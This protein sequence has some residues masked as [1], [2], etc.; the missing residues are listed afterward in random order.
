MRQVAA[1]IKAGD[2]ETVIESDD[3]IQVGNVV[4]GLYSAA[5]RRFGFC[6]CF[7]DKD[8]EAIRDARGTVEW[9]YYLSTEQIQDIAS[10]AITRL[11]MW[12][13]S[14]RDCGR[15]WSEP[16]GNCPRCDSRH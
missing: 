5:E 7:R 3:L 12:H 14:E 8:D 11:A 6:M 16:D 13:C 2:E 4:G 9:C 15:R 10:G 1:Q